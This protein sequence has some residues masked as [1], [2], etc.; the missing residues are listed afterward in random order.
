MTR[1]TIFV[2]ILG[3]CLLLFPLA[4]MTVLAQPGGDTP[5]PLPFLTP[6]APPPGGDGNNTGSGGLPFTL[7]GGGQPPI[8]EQ[9]P[10]PVEVQPPVEE[11]P[12][13]DT[14]AV[15]V[16]ESAPL[17]DPNMAL[18]QQ[19]RTDLERLADV[20]LG[21]VRPDGWSGAS[22]ITNPQFAIL[23]RLDLELLVGALM[24]AN[25]RPNGWFGVVSSTSYA[26]SRD[27]RHDLELLA[28][29][30]L[31]LSVRPDGW[32]GASPIIRC[33]RMT[34]AVVQFLELNGVFQLQA[35]PTSPDYCKQAA[36]EAS[37]FMEVNILSSPTAGSSLSMASVG[38]VGGGASINSDFAAAF[39][40]RGAAQRVG[41]VPNGTPIEVV[42]KSPAQFSNMMLVRGQ[43]FEVFVDY[44]FTSIT[45]DEFEFIPVIDETTMQLSCTARWC[46]TG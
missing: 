1:R 28:D 17:V 37:V 9:Q 25:T 41:V 29:Q 6:N 12:P 24:G 40:D 21:G 8:G 38:A 14:E 35:D 15:D 19:A 42:G 26:I 36:N 2:T 44:Q 7:P 11:Q 4:M 16:P 33:D 46:T 45:E 32:I 3:I 43:D 22:D 10:P 20:A 39:L 34:Q 30:H 23:A 5:P 18:A 13:A 27:I 31:G